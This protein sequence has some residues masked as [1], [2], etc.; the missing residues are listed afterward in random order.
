MSGG[1]ATG[2]SLVKTLKQ[3]DIGKLDVVVGTHT[4]EDHIG[5]LD[6]VLNRF[7]IGDILVIEGDS[8]K[9]D[10]GGTAK[11]EYPEDDE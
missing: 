6:V 2:G 4:H 9:I 7:D 11:K 5:G 3:M 8:I 1:N 10:S